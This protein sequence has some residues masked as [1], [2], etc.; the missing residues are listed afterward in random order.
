MKNLPFPIISVTVD[1]RF[2]ATRVIMKEKKNINGKV[3]VA[4][5]I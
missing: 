5:D 4:I 2:F 1:N 3:S